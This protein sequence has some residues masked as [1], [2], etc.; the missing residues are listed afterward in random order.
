MQAQ[1]KM[2]M[3]QWFFAVA[4]YACFIASVQFF[5]FKF[6]LNRIAVFFVVIGIP[7]MW[8]LGK[9]AKPKPN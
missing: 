1:R 2:N 3:W 8:L 6:G 9:L 5:R 7:L 4:W